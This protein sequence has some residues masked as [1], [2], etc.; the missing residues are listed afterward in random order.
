MKAIIMPTAGGPEVLQY[1]EVPAPEI[2]EPNQIKVQIHA[3]GVNPVDTKIR[4]NGVFSGE[5]PAI[6]GCD[7]AGVVIET[8]SDVT[9]LKEGDQVWFCNGGLGGKQGNYAE[10]TVM[11]EWQAQK[12][13]E[14]LTFEQAAA[15]PLVL[16]TAWE[17]LVTQ[18]K[19]QAGE[20]VLVHA[21]GGGVGHVAIQIAKYRG[22]HVIASVRSEA[23]GE[24]AQALGAD[25][26]VNFL[27]EDWPQRI[28]EITNG[29]GVDVVFDTVGPDVFKASMQIIRPYGRIVTLL[30]PGNVEWKEARNKNVTVSFTFMLAPW[31]LNLE[32]HWLR[33]GEIL[34]RCSQLFDE[35]KL[36]I[37][38]Q[39]VFPLENAADAHR[40]IEEG[41]VAGKLVLS[42]GKGE[43]TQN[44]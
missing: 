6:L 21:G 38:I 33:Q 14:S 18:A 12:K 26:V 28:R 8:G 11:E 3:A 35:E 27:D 20:T 30:D 10:Y 23:K 39:H 32:D 34:S 16:I 5:L 1:S 15:A 7:G 43:E 22:A 24:L 40:L 2:T 9:R 4:K 17:A 36:K 44:G 37:E 25:D 42:M 29:Q 31:I 41:H 13:P 19:V